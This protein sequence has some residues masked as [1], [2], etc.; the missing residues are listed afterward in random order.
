MSRFLLII[1]LFLTISL[2][3]IFTIILHYHFPRSQMKL[4][5]PAFVNNQPIPDAYSCKGKNVSPPLIISD[6]PSDAVSLALTMIDPDA[7]YGTFTHWVVW[8]IP[9]NKTTIDENDLFSD[10]EIGKN[11]AGKNGYMGPCP[12]PRT[13][14]NYHFAVYALNEKIDIPPGSGIADL[15]KAMTGHIVANGELIGQFGREE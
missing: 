14:H 10:A 12:P 2:I 9:K 13:I 4:T 3:I 11:S 5:S 15:E 7:P 8:N 1:G 6:I